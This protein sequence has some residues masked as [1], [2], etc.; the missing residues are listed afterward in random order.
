MFHDGGARGRGTLFEATLPRR[1]VGWTA[2]PR[3]PPGTMTTVVHRRQCRLAHSRPVLP[4]GLQ[5]VEWLSETNRDLMASLR[6]RSITGRESQRVQGGSRRHSIARQPNLDGYSLTTSGDVN[7]ATI[8]R[9]GRRWSDIQRVVH[10]NTRSPHL[11][12][13]CDGA[14]ASGVD[15]KSISRDLNGDG[16]RA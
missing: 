13:R 3:H 12:F 16:A 9:S 2:R 6:T 14:V 11:R 7:D 8:P 1:G 4:H 10:I 5:R 15:D